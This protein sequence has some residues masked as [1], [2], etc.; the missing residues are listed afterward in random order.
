M[1]LCNSIA[2]LVTNPKIIL[3]NKIPGPGA[4]QQALAESNISGKQSES[5][6]QKQRQ[7]HFFHG[8]LQKLLM[9]KVEGMAG[10]CQEL[11]RWR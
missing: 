7:Q 8:F 3:G 11:S 6:D 5:A 9:V 4:V 1:I 10:I 2:V